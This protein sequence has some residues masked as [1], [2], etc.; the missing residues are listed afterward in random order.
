MY[1]IPRN[2]LTNYSIVAVDD[3]VDCLAVLA[4][5]LQHYNATVYTATNGQ[6]ALTIIQSIQPALV[7][8]DLLMP[9]MD[10]WDML[11]TLQRNPQLVQIPV[12]A[13]T[14]HT[15]RG[16]RQ[17]AL[18]AG[19]QTYLTKPLTP[20]ILIREL[21]LVLIENGEITLDQALIKHL[22]H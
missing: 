10:G 8:S 4:R 15:W 21:L 7:I 18:A 14:A 16:D 22:P 6:D 3:E 17:R 20:N 12:I 9:R 2:V 5:T 11:K 13:L 19:F 1:K